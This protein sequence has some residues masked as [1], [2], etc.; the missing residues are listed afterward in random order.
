MKHIVSAI[1]AGYLKECNEEEVWNLLEVPSLQELGDYSLPCFSL[2][3]KRKKAPQVIAQELE[4]QLT[5]EN[6]NGI[7]DHVI[8]MNGYLNVFL[9]RSQCISMILSRA[10]KD[11]YGASTIGAGKTI[12]MDYSSPNIAKN[13][14]VGHLRT[15]LIGNSL[16]NIY[17][18]LGYQ[19]VRINYLG[20]WGTQFG[21]LITAYK[22]WSSKEKVEAYGIEELLRIYVLFSKEAENN[23][24]LMDEARMWF[25]RMEAK[26]E[27]ALFLWTWFKKIS[28]IEFE[29]IYELLN[30]KFDCYS[31]ES[32]YRDQ[33]AHLVDELAEKHL[34][35]E[36]QGANVVML[37]AYELPPCLIQKKDGS[38]IYTSRD[39][40]A[41][42]DRKQQYQFCKCLYVTGLEQKL[43]FAQVFQVLQLMGDDW[44]KDMVHV[45]YGLV[46][47]DG[48]KLSSR[49][50]TVIYAEDILQEAVKRAQNLIEE[51]NP[52]LT[53]K[54]TIAKQVGIGAIIFHDL[55]NQ[56][57]KNINFKWD[58]VLSFSGATAAYIQYTYARA[59]SIL[60]KNGAAMQ[61]TMDADNVSLHLCDDSSYSLL[62]LL[63]EYPD[64]II[65]AARLLVVTIAQKIIKDAMAL[66]E[67]QCPEEM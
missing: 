23:P 45:P 7:I 1:L 11:D 6:G 62:R 64:K 47:L 26:D 18:K 59:N 52:N 29:R 14:H 37:D 43:H 53:D 33:V 21:K 15:T 39:I 40:A 63:N 55:Y 24:D 65:E 28:L 16:A 35:V 56:R 30:V 19:V 10:A 41:A 44:A 32:C 25:S 5:E 27:E 42:I 17:S 36:S 22:K 9:D 2:A 50:G 54:E 34:L 13:F 38:S 46:S 31:G 48:E 4:K 60:R 8:S 58:D 51:K 49:N 67:I 66:L 12:C 20:D 3:K 57:I 61:E